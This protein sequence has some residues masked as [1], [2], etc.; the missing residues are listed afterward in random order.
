[1][2]SIPLLDDIDKSEIWMNNI[3]TISVRINMQ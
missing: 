2:Y 3:N 1:M